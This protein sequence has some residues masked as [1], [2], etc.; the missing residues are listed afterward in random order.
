M[1]TR[2][3][4][5][6]RNAIQKAHQEKPIQSSGVFD[7]WQIGARIQANSGECEY[8]S[9]AEAHTITGGFTMYPEGDP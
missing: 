4:E 2:K 1:H 7:F 3:L 8:S 6:R 5:Q 9:H